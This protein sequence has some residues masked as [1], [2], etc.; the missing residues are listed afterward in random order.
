MV[1]FGLKF[2]TLFAR[3]VKRGRRRRQMATRIGAGAP[4]R[5]CRRRRLGL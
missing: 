4:G 3:A 5:A 1:K 2:L